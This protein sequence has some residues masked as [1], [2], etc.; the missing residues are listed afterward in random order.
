MRATFFVLRETQP[1]KAHLSLL[2][3]LAISVQ[4][5]YSQGATVV[6][7]LE[8][9]LSSFPRV[10]DFNMNAEGTEAYTTLQSPL[11]EVSIIVRMNKEEGTW[12]GTWESTWQ[13]PNIASF[14]GTYK[15]LEPFLSPD[16]LT[17]YFVSNRP[18]SDTSTAPKDFDIWYVERESQDAPWSKPQNLGAPVNTEHNEFY[19]VITNS[20]NL[21]YTFDGP[22]VKG[23][24]DIFLATWNG[25]G[26]A[27]PYSMDTTINTAGFEYNAYVD[28]DET[29]M[30]FGGYNREDGLGSGDIYLSVRKEG[31]WQQAE[32]Q[33]DLINS[34]YMDYCPFVD[35]THQILYF[36]SRRSSIQAEAISS[37]EAFTEL[38]SQY[39]NGQSRI[40]QMD[41]S[42]YL[43]DLTP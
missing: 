39:E 16:G 10:R 31:I 13:A 27:P 20:G 43:K 5:G 37:M 7:G 9:V 28:P 14:S 2:L 18:V 19:P 36:T 12:E 34:K 22:G 26:F 1:M 24:D 15:D 29:F 23:R 3:I 40:Y 17:L 30:L 21:Y 4:L 11:E 32:N 42:S 6:P 38:I 8:E 41:F 25:E 35:L 33:G